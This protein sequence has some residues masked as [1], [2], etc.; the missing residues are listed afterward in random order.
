MNIRGRVG[1]LEVVCGQ[2]RPL[3]YMSDAEL[4]ARIRRLA[5][6]ELGL[7]DGDAL[8]NEMLELLVRESAHARA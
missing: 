1:K 3:Q 8:T 6:A 7:S 5:G 4:E 2:H